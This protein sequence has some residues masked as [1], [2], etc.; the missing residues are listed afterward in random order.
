MDNFDKAIAAVWE[1]DGI[2]NDSAPGEHFLTT[3]GITADTWAHAVDNGMV[4]DKPQS[5]CT[6]D[7]A[8]TILR[9]LYWDVCRCQE[10]PTGVDLMVFDFAMMAG[11]IPAGRSLQLAIDAVAIPLHVDGVIGPHTIAAADMCHAKVLIE[12]IRQ[13]NLDRLSTLH[14][15][16]QFRNGW[17]RRQNTMRDTAL[18]WLV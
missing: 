6:P 18:H 11:I 7:D 14:N 13:F 3:Y 15:W 5:Q 9:F 16:Q 8:K 12:E 1:F 10:L 4:R 2:K 17:T